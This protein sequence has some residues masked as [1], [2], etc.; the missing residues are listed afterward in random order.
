M[1]VPPGGGV[2][3]VKSQKRP[4]GKWCRP[5]RPPTKDFL[6]NRAAPWPSLSHNKKTEHAPRRSVYLLPRRTKTRTTTAFYSSNLYESGSAAC[7]CA[8]HR[9]VR[10]GRVAL[11]SRGPSASQHAHRE[12]RRSG[13]RDHGVARGHAAL[14]RKSRTRPNLANRAG[15][16]RRAVTGREGALLS[17]LIPIPQSDGDDSFPLYLRVDG[18]T[19][20]ARLA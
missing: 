8:T 2:W 20:L 12:A 4:G 7:H 3:P 9:L 5:Q 13:R 1:A 15:K 10:R 14:R 11:V 18:G 17:R 6:H 19:G 16:S